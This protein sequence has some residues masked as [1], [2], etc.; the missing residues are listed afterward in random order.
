[1]IRCRLDSAF[2]NHSVIAAIR[3]ARAQFSITA[4]M[5]RAVTKAIADIPET[6]W[7][8]IN[9]PKA[10]FD[11]EQQ[12]WISDAQVA[13]TTYAAFT[14]LSRKHHVKA[15]LI[16]RRVKRLNPAAAPK[17]QPALFKTHRYHTVFTNSTALMLTAEA[18]HRDHAIVEQVIADLKSNALAH[19]PSSRM[20][21]NARLVGL[22]GHRLQPDPAM[23]VLGGGKFAKARTSTTRSKLIG[24]PAR[25]ATTGRATVLHLPSDHRHEHRFITIL[26]A[27]QAPPEAA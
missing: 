14:S 24:V 21:A 20:N 4:R 16:V 10:I 2:Y 1:M 23:G 18:E 19:L 8:S 3:K 27:V 9:Y 22:C 17:G 15:R 6:A 25:I 5:D 12:R 11:D 7:V 26:D 13:E